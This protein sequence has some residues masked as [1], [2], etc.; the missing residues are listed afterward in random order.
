MI[1]KSSDV[2]CHR[3]QVTAI[4]T[5]CLPTMLKLE[6]R[7]KLA[8]VAS[9]PVSANKPRESWVERL[10][11]RLQEDPLFLKNPFRPR[12]GASDWCGIATMIDR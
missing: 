4:K 12:T 7:E 5:G 1:W 6:K 3:P 2:T 11:E 8:C 9:V 10:R